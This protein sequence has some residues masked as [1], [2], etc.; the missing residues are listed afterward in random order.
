[1]VWTNEQEGVRKLSMGIN[2]ACNGAGIDQSGMGADQGPSRLWLWV[3]VNAL[4]HL[5][6]KA[7]WICGIEPPGNGGGAE[8]GNLFGIEMPC[9]IQEK[10]VK[11]QAAECS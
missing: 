11:K 5:V 9:K 7:I 8:H 6:S 3:F 2:S 4:L 10:M 1:M